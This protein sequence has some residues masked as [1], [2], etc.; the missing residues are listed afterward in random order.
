[1][2]LAK[3][4]SFSHHP[5]PGGPGGLSEWG[6][7]LGGSDPGPMIF[8]SSE[9][10]KKAAASV[11]PKLS[12]AAAPMGPTAAELVEAKKLFAQAS[13]REQEAKKAAEAAVR[14]VEG[15]AAKNAVL[16]AKV[17]ALTPDPTQP[18]AIDRERRI[19]QRRQVEEAKV[20]EREQYRASVTRAFAGTVALT[21][22][23]QRRDEDRDVWEFNFRTLAVRFEV[24]NAAGT[25]RAWANVRPRNPEEGRFLL[26]MHN[27]V[28]QGGELAPEDAVFRVK[29]WRWTLFTPSQGV[30]FY[31]PDRAGALLRLELP[32]LSG[33]TIPGPATTK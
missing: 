28:E 24:D 26:E 8:S 29:Q 22:L 20:A 25:A 14:L 3:V 5:R 9:N 21:E 4:R 1:M 15:L 6:L 18:D 12:T 31:P 13:L 32:S 33:P 10:A 19:D 16:E 11:A 27:L 23:R 30:T 17:A 2:T 7:D